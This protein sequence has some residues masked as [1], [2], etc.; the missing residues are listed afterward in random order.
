MH[1][2][3]SCTMWLR[4]SRDIRK[5]RYAKSRHF[6]SG[7]TNC[8]APSWLGAPPGACV[9]PGAGSEGELN[10]PLPPLNPPPPPPN[11]P[12]PPPGPP[13]PPPGPPLPGGDGNCASAGVSVDEMQDIAAPNANAHII[14]LSIAKVPLRKDATPC[15]VSISSVGSVPSS[16]GG[17]RVG[18]SFVARRL[19][20]LSIAHRALRR[21]VRSSGRAKFC[22][23]QASTQRAFNSLISMQYL[24]TNQSIS[25]ASRY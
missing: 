12:P 10:P 19:R 25:R 23:Y 13:L 16:G 1:R 24:R 15:T 7:R 2:I 4:S 6:S 5:N 17:P 9:G 21:L 18:P 3:R 8:L 14:V 22:S 11:P 20:H